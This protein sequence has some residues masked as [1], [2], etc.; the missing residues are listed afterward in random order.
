MSRALC[1]IA[2]LLGKSSIAASA[3][4]VLTSPE[5]VIEPAGGISPQVTCAP[6]NIHNVAGSG[7][8][9][10]YFGMTFL[11][12]LAG[13]KAELV[14]QERAIMEIL[15]NK[16]SSE[17]QLQQL[18]EKGCINPTTL[19]MK[20][21]KLR[22]DH[23]KTLT[24]HFPE[25]NLESH[26]E[27][28]D[29]SWLDLANTVTFGVGSTVIGAARYLGRAVNRGK[30]ISTGVTGYSTLE[31]DEIAE[32]LSQPGEAPTDRAVQGSDSDGDRKDP[33]NTITQAGNSKQLIL[34]SSTR[35]RNERG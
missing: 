9:T 13:R 14:E 25:H 4:P 8:L 1:E 24:D 16:D 33:A 12:G 2:K 17:E 34:K 35:G 19:Q 18:I 21:K 29:K 30:R 20:F 27:Q 10:K 11:W 22:D 28:E 26:H 32:P 23:Y 5:A 31:E 6:G 3:M 15:A 7:A